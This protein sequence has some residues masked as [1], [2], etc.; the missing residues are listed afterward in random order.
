MR[1]VTGLVWAGIF[2]W[3]ACG[4][5]REPDRLSVAAPDGEVTI[6]V[7]GRPVLSYATATRLPEG[8]EEHYARSGFLHP[9]YTPAGQVVTDDFPHGHTHQHGIFTA[10]TSATFRGDT[11]DFWNQH[12][13]KGTARHTELLETYD[14]AG[15]AGFRARLEQVSLRH[16]PILKED[17]HVRVYDHSAPYVWELHSTQT[18]VTNDT[19]FLNKYL[20]GGL[21]VRG[22][23]AWNADDTVAFR[24]PAR[25]LTSEGLDRDA[26]NHSRPAWVAIYGPLAGGGA[27]GGM[28]VFPHPDNFRDPQFVRVHPEMPYLSVTPVAEE[29]FPLPPGAT[30][31]ARYRFVT[32]DGPAE[33]AGLDAFGWS[34]F[35]GE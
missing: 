21:G 34:S 26:A 3:T 11:I 8:E 15:V 33:G 14:S 31:V 16:G 13:E 22:S 29:G 25:F 1:I 4:T 24:G 10:W 28:A 23:A 17:W 19:L 2:W 35:G 32:F 7:D 27:D 12:K 18:N 20:Y 30:Y 5:P 6:Q 9:V